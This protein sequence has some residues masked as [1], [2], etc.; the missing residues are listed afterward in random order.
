MHIY[1]TAHI[2]LSPHTL[3]LIILVSLDE[4]EGLA[5]RFER[6][7]RDHSGT[8][9]AEEMLGI[10][11]F[12]MNPL[13]PRIL[14]LLHTEQEELDFTGF[15][16]LLSIFHA[17]AQP[18]EKLECTWHIIL[19]THLCSSSSVAFKVYN[20]SGDGYIK[21]DE[22]LSILRLMAGHNLQDEELLPIVEQTFAC[23]DHNEDGVIDQQEFIQVQS[24]QLTADLLES[25]CPF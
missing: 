22:L 6:L 23:A 16:Q 3:W 8:L 4:L 11:E 10:P 14:E 1:R 18:Q 12:S 2:V 15:T 5:R 21:K 19:S 13:A 17:R 9:S 20:I 7:D 24:I 25:E